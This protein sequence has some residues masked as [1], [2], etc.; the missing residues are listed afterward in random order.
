MM[1]VGRGS[2]SLYPNFTSGVLLKETVSPLIR[3]HL[4][5]SGSRF[6]HLVG[7]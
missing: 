2:N 4:G 5:Y 1:Y 6:E 7:D 3:V